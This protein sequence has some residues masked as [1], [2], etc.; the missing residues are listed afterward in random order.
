MKNEIVLYRPNELAEHIEVRLDE[1]NETFWLTQEQVAQL[2]GRDRTVISKHLK[3]IFKEEELEE[4]VVCAFFAHTTKHGAIKGKTQN[5]SVKYYNLDAILSVGYRVNSK[6]GTQFRIWASRVLK[7]YLLKGYAINN[8]M[9]RL[10]DNFDSLENKVN[11][12]DLQINT[13]LI[14]TQGIFFNGQMFDAYVFAADLIKSAQK[15][16]ILIDN[17][18]DET[19]LNLLTKRSKNIEATIY[20]KNIS[21]ALRQDLEKH[22]SQYPP[23]KILSLRDSHDRFLIIDQKELYHIGASLKD[24]GKKWFAFSKMSDLLPE[25]LDKL[26]EQE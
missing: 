13:H 15:E 22:N 14:P 20:T 26:D 1:E 3:N 9:N 8:R 18:V 25:L 10:E 6:Q 23:I 2:F 21:K 11:Q 19:A 7:D 17:Y 16:I 24:L 5:K 12:I 4:K